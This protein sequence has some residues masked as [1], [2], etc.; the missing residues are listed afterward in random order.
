MT[1][2]FNDGPIIIEDKQCILTD[3]DKCCLCDNRI[4]LIE[5]GNC[6]LRFCNEIH[7]NQSDIIFHLQ[8]SKHNIIKAMINSL[9]PNKYEEIKCSK[10]ENNNVFSLFIL[11]NNE[12]EDNK[13]IRK[14]I[15]CSEHSPKKDNLQ[16]VIEKE[17]KTN[18][19]III[20]KNKDKNR[21]NFINKVDKNQI[22]EKQKLL[23]DFNEFIH[24]KLN[25][26]KLK[27]DNK[28]DYYEIYKPLIVAD[29]L[30]TKKI[31]DNKIEYDIKLLVNKNEKYYFQVPEDFIEINFAPGRVL[32]FIEVENYEHMDDDYEPIQ[33]VGVITN[34]NFNEGQL[35]DIWIMPIN[36][37][38]TS[39]KGHTGSY[40]IKEE[41]CSIPYMRMLE[42]LELFQTD[43]C[44][45]ENGGAVSLNLV[46]RILGQYPTKKD[47][48]SK[49]NVPNIEEFKKKE[50][51]ALR[52]LFNEK[53]PFVNFILLETHFKINFI[54]NCQH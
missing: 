6:G 1:E 30:F 18:D 31:Y 17:E 50:E 32:K 11:I 23:K 35:Y 26:V 33:F 8:D 25:K 44:E 5:C 16:P 49:K 52:S 41:F 43:E 46:R 47:L 9:C 53:N 10:C 54:Y 22:R 13:D 34:L 15:F 12:N 51:K 45:D 37:H 28:Y 29:Y 42:A 19:S 2:D 24:R 4:G 27:Y 36:K 21:H 40:K 39:L 7:D 48:N 3:K 14:Y 20:N 38:I